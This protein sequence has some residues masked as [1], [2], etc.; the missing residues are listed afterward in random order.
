MIIEYSV[1]DLKDYYNNYYDTNT[2]YNDNYELLENIISDN[3]DN[4]NV[5]SEILHYF[6]LYLTAMTVIISFYY[7]I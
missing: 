1:E 3:I 2:H 6:P 7:Y 5:N 4:S